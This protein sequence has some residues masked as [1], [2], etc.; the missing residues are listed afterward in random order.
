M[1]LQLLPWKCC[2]RWLQ[3]SIHES[4]QTVLPQAF[5]NV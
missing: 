5:Y 4:V 1:Q 2:H 3:Q